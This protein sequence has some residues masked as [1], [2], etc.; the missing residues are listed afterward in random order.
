MF[1]EQWRT[2]VTNSVRQKKRDEPV[3]LWTARFWPSWNQKKH[4]SWYLLRHEQVETR[5]KKESWVST[6]WRVRY[7]WHN[8][9]NNL[10]PTSCC[11]LEKVQS[12]TKWARRMVNNYSFVPRIFD[13]SRLSESPSFGSYSWRHNHWTNLGSSYWWIHLRLSHPEKLSVLWMIFMITKKSSGPL[14]NC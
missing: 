6:G 14:T 1:T 2:G 7:S 3:L 4:N 8:C 10:L 5:C 11:S 13:F 9:V 12:S